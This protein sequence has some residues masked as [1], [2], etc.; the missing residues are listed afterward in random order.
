[1]DDCSATRDQTD[2]DILTLTLSDDTLEAAAAT[3]ETEKIS[4]SACDS[5]ALSCY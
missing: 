3:K 5:S 4:L 1:M 2:E